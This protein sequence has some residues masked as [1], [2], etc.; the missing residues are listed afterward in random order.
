M[1]AESALIAV[2][3]PCWQGETTL[4][5]IAER[6]RGGEEVDTSGVAVVHYPFVLLLAS[7]REAPKEGKG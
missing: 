6:L 4:G 7:M 5:E 2:L 3:R 1:K